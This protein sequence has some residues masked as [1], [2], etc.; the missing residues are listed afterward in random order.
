MSTDPYADF[1]SPPSNLD[2]VLIQLADELQAAEKVVEDAQEA[3]TEAKDVLKDITDIRVPQATDGLD[4]KFNLSDGRTILVKEDI[5]SSIAGDK[6]VP[7]I[8]WLDD[9][10]YGFI[11][12]RNVV[13]TFAKGDDK[14]HKKFLKKVEKFKIPLVM[15]EEYS[16]HHATLNAWIKEQMAEGVE[17]PEEKFG[18]YRQRVAKVKDA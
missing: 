12:K 2:A 1:K 10:D 6:R 11:V 4:G 8:K 18:I 15:K 14:S 17:L 13:F 7:A 9:H 16:V 3:L 5:R